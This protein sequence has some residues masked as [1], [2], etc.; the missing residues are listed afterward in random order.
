V[1]EVSADAL[2][3][4]VGVYEFAPGVRSTVMLEGGHLF[5]QTTGQQRGELLPVGAD[6]FYVPPDAEGRTR[7]ERD[8]SGRVA[9]QI[10]ASGGQEFRAA[11]VE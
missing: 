10:Y 9:V 7:F 1:I 6:E 4:Y 2:A 3:Q 8:A 5:E 11:R